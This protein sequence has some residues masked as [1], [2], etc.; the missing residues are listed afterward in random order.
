MTRVLAIESSCDETAAAV[1]ADG[2][3]LVSNVVHTQVAVHASFGGVVPEV[4]AREHMVHLVD[5][6]GRAVTQ[7]GGLDAIDAIAVTQG[8]GLLGALL[9][10]LQFAKGL[11]VARGLPFIGINHLE[12]HLAAADLCPDKP[13]G[14]HVALVVSGGHTHIYHVPEPGHYALL[15]ATRDDAAGE[16][17]DKVAKMLGLGYPGGPALEAAARGGDRA[18]FALPRAWLGAKRPGS[19]TK[20]TLDFSFSGLKTAAQDVLFRRPLPWD[21]TFRRDFCASLQ[22]AIVDVLTHKAV[23]AAVSVGARGIILAGGVAANGRLRELLQERAQH[24]GLFAF[25]PPKGLCT[26]NA[27]MVAAAGWRRLAAGERSD[28]TISARARWPLGT[29]I[30]PAAPV[31]SIVGA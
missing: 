21:D 6:V 17:F 24:N 1:V 10:G 31:A 28:L 25:A 26:D 12:G 15:G 22:E 2:P 23:A 27:A 20:P 13:E 29:P 5:V 11:A 30:A 16:A 8:P 18:A 19:A 7:A 9:V 3:T 14:P 4:A